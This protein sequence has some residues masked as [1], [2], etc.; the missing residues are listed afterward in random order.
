MRPFL[1]VRPLF[2]YRDI[3]RVRVLLL[4]RLDRRILRYRWTLNTFDRIIDLKIS[5]FRRLSESKT[6]SLS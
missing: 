5:F 4:E 3:E 2:T 6:A 1:R